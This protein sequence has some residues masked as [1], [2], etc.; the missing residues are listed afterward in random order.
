MLGEGHQ[1]ALVQS[2]GD[3]ALKTPVAVHR[4]GKT[5]HPVIVDAGVAG[6]IFRI[7]VALQMFRLADV[8]PGQ[9]RGI[10]SPRR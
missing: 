10:N 8:K 5:D 2:Q 9:P 4:R 3:D 1:M 6:G 7:G